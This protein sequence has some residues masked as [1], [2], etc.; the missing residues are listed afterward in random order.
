MKPHEIDAL[1][2]AIAAPRAAPTIEDHH[3]R[4]RAVIGH[5]RPVW[6][7]V[8]VQ[9][10]AGYIVR[11]VWDIAQTSPIDP[12]KLLPTVT[13]WVHDWL[14]GGATYAD[15]VARM[16]RNIEELG[17]LVVAEGRNPLTGE[18]LTGKELERA[19]KGGKL[20]LQ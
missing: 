2:A 3:Q 5:H 7:A 17:A 14:L 15:I 16:P 19:Q 11:T 12:L 4:L 1:L 20:K 9:S 10:L 18:K 8:V 6:S 13:G